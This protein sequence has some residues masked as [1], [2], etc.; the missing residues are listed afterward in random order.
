[1]PGEAVTSSARIVLRDAAGRSDVEVE[2]KLAPW[3]VAWDNGF[4][5][6]AA[7]ILLLALVWEAYGRLLDNSLLF[8]T[9]TETVRALAGHVADGSL[10]ARAW[11]SIKVLL[12]G[13]VAGVLLAGALTILAINTRIGSDF[14]ETVTGMLS[15]LPAIALLPLALLW[16]GLGNGS[17][18]FILV[19]SV[20]WPVALNTHSGFR[21]VSNTLRMVGRNYGLTGFAFVRKI[22]IPAAFPSILAGLKIGWA[23]AWRTLVAAELVFGVSSGQGGLGWFI[24]ENRNQ[25]EIP[26]VFAGLLTVILIGLVVENLIFRNVERRTVLRWGLQT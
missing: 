21:A 23:F 14:L 8:P 17:L 24:F 3:E 15:P 26:S 2:R 22:L 4:V 1:M 10:P 6:K 12:M 20:L 5:R 18:V 9:L 25:L 7:I 19:H 11:A 16:F 13:Y